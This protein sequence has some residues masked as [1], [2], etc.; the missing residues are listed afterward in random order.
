MP[1]R[2]WSTPSPSSERAARASSP[3]RVQRASSVWR[4]SRSCS[5]AAS[6][7]RFKGRSRARASRSMSSARS[8]LSCVRASLS[9]ARRRRLRCLPRPAASSISSRRSRGLEVTI[10]STRP[11]ETTECISLPE[12]GVG[13]D[14]HHVDEPALRA[15][16]AVLALPRAVEPAGDRDLAR[17]QVDGA[18]AVV[19]H[20]LDLG[21]RARLHAVGAGEDH[22]LHRL[23]ADGQRRLLAHRPQHRVGDVGLAGAIRADDHGHAG[24]ELEPRAVRERLE[25]LQRDRPQMHASAPQCGSASSA[26]AAAACSASF[27]ERPEPRATSAPSTVADTSKV[28]SCGGPSSPTTS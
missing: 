14:L 24:R 21:L 13:E 11:W 20:D 22:V 15:V 2:T 28:R 1:H 6:A 27:F 12:P 9:W 19:E 26:A 5:S 8:R 10:D 16:D 25:A 7:W 18:V 4:S 23:A 17:G 3:A